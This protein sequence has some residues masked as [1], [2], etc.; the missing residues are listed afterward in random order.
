MN[1]LQPPDPLNAIEFYSKYYIIKTSFGIFFFF[2]HVQEDMNLSEN[3]RQPIRNRDMV[4]KVDMLCS[5]KRRQMASQV[6]QRY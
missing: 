3:L 5:F 1:N 4:T 6:N 2:F